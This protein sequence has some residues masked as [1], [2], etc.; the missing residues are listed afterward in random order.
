M[1][2]LDRPAELVFRKLTEGLAKVGDCRKIDD[3]LMAEV[4]EQTTM[5]PLVWLTRFDEHPSG[6]LMRDVDVV[7]LISSIKAITGDLVQDAEE[8]IY[9]ISYRRDG[10]NKE[11]IIIKDGRWNVQLE[12]QTTICRFA[13]Q[14]M[15]S[16]SEERKV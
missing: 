4:V 7:F 14:W 9:P 16:I 6:D 5:G 2:S 12:L 15:L 1:K 13:E 8:R 3:T 11:S 10:V